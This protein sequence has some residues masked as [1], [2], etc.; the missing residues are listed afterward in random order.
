[1]TEIKHDT[2]GS[3][4]TPENQ[5][6]TFSPLKEKASPSTMDLF[7]LKSLVELGKIQD[8]ITIGN[9]VFEMTT[10][11]DI[12]QAKAYDLLQD[13]EKKLTLRR[14][15]VGLSLVTIN[16]RTPEEIIQSD[17]PSDEKRMELVANLQGAVV[18]KLLEFYDSLLER[19]QKD[20]SD[21]SVKN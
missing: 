8:T 17:K 11:D 20:I 5:K 9:F 13:E 3:V 16:G 21:E 18:D 19:S 7:D 1:M 12:N 10:L 2:F 4:G 14:I 15:V 6:T